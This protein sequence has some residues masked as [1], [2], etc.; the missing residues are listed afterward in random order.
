MST[1]RFH[2]IKETLTR[3]PIIILE[4]ERRS[5]IFGNNVF[6][7]TAMRQYLT[8]EA[9]ES[10]ND[11]ILKGSKI[12]R[13]VANHIATGMKEWS[14]SK[15]ATHYTHWFQPLT[16]ATA[17]KHDA[18]FGEFSSKDLFLEA[19]EPNKSIQRTTQFDIPFD[20]EKQYK[21]IIRPQKEQSTTDTAVVC[22]TNC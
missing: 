18:F 2:A 1:L 15:G 7:Q 8:K 16:G 13:V 4:K 5:S 6:N 3:K 14:T 11:A 22:I 20:D 9:L 10:I 12:N 17:E 21:I 19:L